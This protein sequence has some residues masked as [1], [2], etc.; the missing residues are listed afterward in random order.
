[1]ENNSELDKKI[2]GENSQEVS[3]Q[4]NGKMEVAKLLR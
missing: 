1:M 3:G 4:F 2:S